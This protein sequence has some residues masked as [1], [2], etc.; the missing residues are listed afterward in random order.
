M[1]ALVG[2]AAL[3]SAC[4]DP[5][6]VSTE[7]LTRVVQAYEQ[8]HPAPLCGLITTGVNQAGQFWSRE[9]Q[10][11]AWFQTYPA[12]QRHGYVTVLDTFTDGVPTVTVAITGKYLR[13]FGPPVVGGVQRA[14][15]GT[16]AFRRVVNFT[17]PAE[18]A[19]VRVT[20]VTA[21]TDQRVT[22]SWARDAALTRLLRFTP[23]P[24]VGKRTYLLA[25]HGD[26]WTV[27]A[28]R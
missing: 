27:E 23:A 20:T 5:N 25:L 18:V 9:L 21:V 15:Y 1:G 3:L 19:G 17:E 11:D 28:V 14:C 13:D 4:R 22:A 10:R 12:L 16:T 24:P 2:L 8:T 6:A 26:G 7:R